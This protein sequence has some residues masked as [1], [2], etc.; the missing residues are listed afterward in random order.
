VRGHPN[1]VLIDRAGKIVGRILGE[2]DWSS[3]EAHQLVESLLRDGQ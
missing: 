1:T 3:P 2:R